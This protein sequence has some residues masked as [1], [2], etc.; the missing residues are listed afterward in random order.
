MRDAQEPAKEALAKRLKLKAGSKAPDLAASC[1][2]ATATAGG[3]LPLALAW[4]HPRQKGFGKAAGD[5]DVVSFC[6][7]DGAMAFRAVV[8]VENPQVT[9]LSLRHL[10]QRC[11]WL[12]RVDFSECSAMDGNLLTTI[13]L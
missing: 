3:C 7:Q 5:D 6:S 11:T 1:A 2:V 4:R 10:S 8:C 13:V 9:G 12:V